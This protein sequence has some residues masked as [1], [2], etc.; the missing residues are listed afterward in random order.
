ML[1]KDYGA[2]LTAMPS[3]KKPFKFVGKLKFGE[4]LL[5]LWVEHKRFEAKQWKQQTIFAILAL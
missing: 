4:L 5:I 3:F 1:K 2:A